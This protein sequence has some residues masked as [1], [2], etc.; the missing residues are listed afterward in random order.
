MSDE[1]ESKQQTPLDILRHST[2]HV[3]AKAVQ[4]LYPGSMLGIGPPIDN[5]FYYDIDV[6]GKQLSEDD[7]PAIEDEMRKIIAADEPFIR[8]EV[9]REDAIAENQARGEKYKVEIVEGLPEGE[10]TSFYDTGSDWTDLCRGPHV[11]STSHI[12]TFK[13]L[14]VAGAYWRGDEKRPMLQR[15]YGTAWPSQEELDQY[16]W[17][18]E[19]ARRRDHRRIGRD[20]D[21]FSVSEEVGPGLILWHPKGA[22]VRVEAE[23]YCRRTLLANGYDWVFSPHIGRSLLWETSGHLGFYKENMYAPMD[24]DGDEYYAKPMN[25]PFHI[26][27]FRSQIRS[28]RDLPKRFA[29]NG[30]CY[31]YER[32]GVLHGLTRVRGFTQ[33]DAHIF[34]RPDQVED[35][36]KECLALS[37]SILR[38]FGLTDFSAYLSTRPDKFVGDPA[39]WDQATEALRGALDA[40]GLDY[41]VDEGGGAFYGPKIDL[42]VN[43]ALGR[44]WQLSTI[45]F[46]FNEPER[47]DLSFIGED[48]AQHRP[49]MVHRALLGSLERFFG[50]LIEHF[51]GAFPLWLAPVQVLAIPIADRHLDYA[52]Q[53]AT[54]LKQ[55]GI[56][57]EV[58]S[59]RDR[60]QNKIR[61][62]EQQRV[63]YILVMGDRDIQGGTVSVRER[64]AGDLGAMERS[65]FLERV[66]EERDKR[67]TK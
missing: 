51:A 45:Q 5:G 23:D 61:Q 25:C 65:A 55:H 47:F 49:F 60:M 58:D 21:L 4:R 20:M 24:I 3:M 62:A 11:P 48:G 46:D 14:S 36:I 52:G 9:P 43:D 28:Y 64:G 22:I 33:D 54:E 40:S 27:I 19:E 26:Q 59:R 12:P 13:L 30:T 63:P 56:R 29:E 31:R 18:L 38:T 35:E 15:I 34:C 39:V 41:E 2:A 32:S 7:L 44:E 10:V 67:V 16:L 42:K 6:A 66:R 53:V 1:G 8:R 57:V 37:L 50:V 17:R